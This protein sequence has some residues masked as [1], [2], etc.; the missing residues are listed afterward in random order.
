MR[1]DHC[2]SAWRGSP[3]RLVPRGQL[4][5]ARPRVGGQGDAEQLEDDPLDVVLGLLL[6]EAR[7]SSP[8]R[9]SGSGA[10]RGPPRRSGRGRRGPTSR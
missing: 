3:M 4:D 10:A 1:S 2:W 5:G 8:G 9:R 7:A 6:G